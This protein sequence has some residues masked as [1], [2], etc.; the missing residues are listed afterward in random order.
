MLC[1]RNQ[2][3]NLPNKEKAEIAVDISDRLIEIR[4][5]KHYSPA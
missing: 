5:Y 2:E 3:Q 4:L 1:N